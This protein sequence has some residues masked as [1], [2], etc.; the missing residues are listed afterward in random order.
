MLARAVL[1]LVAVGTV[2]A[3]DYGELLDYFSDITAS[4]GHVYDA[5]DSDGETMDCVHVME[6]TD[7]GAWADGVK[8][9]ALYHSSVDPTSP[10][11]DT[12]PSMS[13]CDAD[14]Q[15]YCCESDFTATCGNSHACS[16][17]SGLMGCACADT[18]DA[19][20]EREY[21]VRL[22]TSSDL[23]HWEFVRTLI[24]N[25]DMPYALRP[26]VAADGPEAARTWIVVTHEQWMTSG[27]RIP[28]NIGFKL[29]ATEAD[30]AGGV[31]HG[32]FIAPLSVGAGQSIEGT[33]GFYA[34]S[35]RVDGNGVAVVDADVGLH[36]NDGQ[37]VDQVGYGPLVGF[38]ATDAGL[39]P[40]FSAAR[41]DA[42]NDLF[43]SRGGIGNIG[44][45]QSG[46]LNGVRF[47]AQEAN[48][49]PMPPTLWE[50]WRVWLY[51]YAPSEGDSPDGTGEPTMLQVTTHG[52][53]TAF[54]NPSW[55]VVSCPDPAPVY[56]YADDGTLP[57]DG[58]TCPS[59]QT[60][61][62]SGQ[63]YCCESQFSAHCGNAQSC[64]SNDGLNGC[65]CEA[66]DVATFPNAWPDDAQCLVASYYLFTEGAA[67]G[68]AGPVIFFKVLPVA[69]SLAPTE[70]PAP[71]PT[72]TVTTPPAPSAPV[73]DDDLPLLGVDGGVLAGPGG[74]LLLL[75][76]VLLLL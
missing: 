37:G 18:G 55:A 6:V 8:Y 2:A 65:A 29:Y 14:G 74:V 28:S 62:A 35:V 12:C 36:F 38:G 72:E 51:E 4:E 59:M 23:I 40:T 21:Q 30:L 71:A 22:A 3:W 33:P 44:Q 10:T 17:N 70:A 43:I 15:L 57:P 27:S 25:A 76:G 26:D 64:G 58:Q 56:V 11:P 63:S 68:E 42:Y 75:I 61:D 47:I 5:H 52:G 32:S 13:T 73:G 16:S 66:A 60:C 69:P 45:R 20:T 53:S 50:D 34:A 9:F 7:P 19:A 54:G 31:E 49:G 1:A 24:P 67:D 46:V 39:S 41:A 48:I